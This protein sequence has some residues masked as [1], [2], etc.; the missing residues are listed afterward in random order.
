MALEPGGLVLVHLG[1]L[2]GQLRITQ[3]LKST[4]GVSIELTGEWTTSTCW[5]ITRSISAP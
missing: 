5:T 2:G 1:E 3:S 4:T